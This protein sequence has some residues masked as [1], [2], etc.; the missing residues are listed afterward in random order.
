MK[1][2][3]WQ[4][5]AR[6]WLWLFFKREKQA[7]EEFR[8]AYSRDPNHLQTLLHLASIDASQ[9][10]FTAAEKWFEKALV[11]TPDDSATWFNLAFVRETAGAPARAIPAF[12]ESVRCNPNQD[13]AWYGMGLLARGSAIE[14]IGLRT[15]PVTL[16]GAPAADKGETASKDKSAAQKSI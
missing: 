13:L 5:Y 14:V 10:R 1:F 12:M 11:I 3:H 15:L 6:G 7:Y 9:K 8:L 16:V 2:E 4:H